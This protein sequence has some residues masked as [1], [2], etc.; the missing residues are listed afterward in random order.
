MGTRGQR[1]LVTQGTGQQP[2]TIGQRAAGE[3]ATGY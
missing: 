1:L 3:A 2:V